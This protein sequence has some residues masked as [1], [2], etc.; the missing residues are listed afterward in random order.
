MNALD[1]TTLINQ[2]IRGEVS[3]AANQNLRVEAAFNVMQLLTKRG[4]LLAIASL[5]GESQTP[6]IAVRQ[7][8][9]YWKLIHQ[10]LLKNHFLM[11]EPAEQ[12][13]FM[14]YEERSIPAGYQLNCTEARQLWKAWWTGMR[15]NNRHSIQIDLLI[16]QRNTWYPVRDIACNQGTLFIQ[17]LAAEIALQ[18]DDLIVWLQKGNLP[19]D[20]PVAAQPQPAQVSEASPLKQRLQSQNCSNSHLQKALGA[21]T[22]IGSIAPNHPVEPVAEKAIAPTQVDLTQVLRQHQGRLYVT[23]ALGEVVIEGLDL[24]AWLSME[25]T[26]PRPQPIDLNHYRERESRAIHR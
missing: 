11:I 23:T 8:S 16:F 4:V 21:D 19:I 18:G 26:T 24:K 7:T 6:T 3:L 1:D 9:D 2:F 5:A 12:A 22:A 14:K 17:S 13:G 10:L 25:A 15:H 20:Q